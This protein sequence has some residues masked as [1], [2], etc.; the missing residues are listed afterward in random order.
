LKDWL[1]AAIEASVAPLAKDVLQALVHAPITLKPIADSKIGPLVARLRSK[2]GTPAQPNP[3]QLADEAAAIAATAEQVFERWSA[4]QRSAREASASRAA[5]AEAPAPPAAA[6]AAAA[7]GPDLAPAAGA[8]QDVVADADGD[9]TLKRSKAAD[10]S[11]VPT[12][13][14]KRDGAAPPKKDA[15]DKDKGEEAL[16]VGRW[17]LTH[18]VPCSP[19]LPFQCARA[20]VRAW[21]RGCTVGGW[22]WAASARYSS[23]HRYL[24][25]FFGACR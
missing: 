21:R 25:V 23:S 2:T 17:L 18:S 22:G 14:A 9:R 16:W 11:A 15:A 12:A 19:A 24:E 20:R 5:V 13:T 3:F 4:A 7:G 6:A 10:G 1:K 8:W